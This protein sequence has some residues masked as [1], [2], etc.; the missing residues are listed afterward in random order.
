MS[1]ISTPGIIGKPYQTAFNLIL[2]YGP[3]SDHPR[4]QF[5]LLY[6]LF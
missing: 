4:L 5:D 1:E 2:S 3:L 6:S